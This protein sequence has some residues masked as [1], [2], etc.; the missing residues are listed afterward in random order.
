MHSLTGYAT[1][2]TRKMSQDE[3]KSFYRRNLPHIQTPG[4][5]FFVTFQL[6]GVYT[7]ACISAMENGKITI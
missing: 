1:T 2:D 7:A 4:A 3:L 5:T 6:A